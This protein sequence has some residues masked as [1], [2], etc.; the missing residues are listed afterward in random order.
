MQLGG[1]DV[2]MAFLLPALL[3]PEF[4]INANRFLAKATNIMLLGLI[5]ISAANVK[6]PAR[7][8]HAQT[9]RVVNIHSQGGVAVFNL[10]N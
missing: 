3:L 2:P 6:A 1:A 9:I 10:I 8:R 5:I 7:E 4:I